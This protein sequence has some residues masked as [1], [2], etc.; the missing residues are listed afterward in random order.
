MYRISALNGFLLYPPAAF[1]GLAR[2]I[3]RAANDP[4]ADFHSTVTIVP[5]LPKSSPETATPSITRGPVPVGS[6]V[7]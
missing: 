2:E 5:P 3:V 7:K 6:M 4:A 1:G